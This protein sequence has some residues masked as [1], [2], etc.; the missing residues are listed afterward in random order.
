[1]KIKTLQW[2]KIPRI[3]RVP[4]V[5]GFVYK[6][7][8]AAQM[9]ILKNLDV[10]ESGINNTYREECV[11]VSL[12]TYADRINT[13]HYT[14]K[15]L[16]NQ[17]YKPDR[18]IL[19]LANEFIDKKLPAE[20]R[21]LENFGLE[22]RYCEEL[23]SH[24]K[25][26]FAM[27]EFPEDIIITFDDD[28][29]YPENQIEKLIK[30]HEKFPDCIVANEVNKLVFNENFELSYQKNEGV[31]S[32]GLTPQ[33]M[34]LPIGCGGV[35]YPPN[36]LSKEVFNKENIF[37]LAYTAD[38]LWLKAMELKKGVKAVKT[39]KWIRTLSCVE[40]SQKTHLAQVNVINGG[41]EGAMRKILDTY[42]DIK[43]VIGNNREQ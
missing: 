27:K 35:L 21:E 34:L 40:N 14:I 12:T 24:K 13:V 20:L 11:I 17:T 25:Y 32:F 43:E 26:Y 31:A 18:I 3:I 9:R 42:P 23:R 33:T 1:M 38:D 39:E 41:N 6:A 2:F 37:N 15:T 22:I 8:S 5:N 10:T 36:C 28:I 7:V 4:K 30:T 19:W 16:L 29:I